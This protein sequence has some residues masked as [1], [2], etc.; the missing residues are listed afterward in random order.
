MTPCFFVT[1][2]HGRPDRYR[3]LFAAVAHERPAALFLGGDLFPH[4]MH[5]VREGDT[6]YRDFLHEFLIPGFEGLRDALGSRYP[7]VFLILG[8]DD[9]RAQEEE[10][11]AAA[12]RGLWAHMHNRRIDWAD[13][14][15]YGYAYVPPT[16]FLLKDWE[17]YDVGRYTPPGGVS[18]EEGWRTVAVP[19]N[20]TRYATI[21]DDLDRLAGDR[22]LGRA[23]FLF[24]GPPY[25]TA[26]DLAGI[27]G[28][29]V[30]HAPLDPHVGSVAIRRFI[31]RRQPLLTLH[32]HIH[33]SA[34]LSGSWRHVLGRTHAFGAAHDG[35]E[36]ALVRFDPADPA[37]AVREL[38]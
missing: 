36:L 4:A 8:N 7:E 30:D 19:P 28:K 11:N 3:K 15:V 9:G 37:G 35:P 6:E 31:D 29:K 16:P 2:L 12:R 34:R 5:T 1:D 23:I 13:H 38:L 10:V 20:V 17:R 24:H 18:P 27:A 14:E 25:D 22:D 26:L 32:G 33:E 21:K